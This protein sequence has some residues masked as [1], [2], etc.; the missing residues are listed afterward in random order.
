MAWPRGCRRWFAAELH[1]VV[2]V[3]VQGWRN[4]RHAPRLVA[5]AIVALPEPPSM[6][7]CHRLPFF[8]VA[9]VACLA[10]PAV[11]QSTADFRVLPYQLNPSLD[12]IQLTWFTI[13]NVPGT[14]TV[15]GP[16]LASPLVLASAPVLEPV[17]DYQIPAELTAGGAFPFATTAIFAAPGVPARNWRHKITVTGLQ[18]DSEY[19]FTVAQGASSYGNTFRTAPTPATNRPLRFIAISDSETLV[20]GRTRFR[21]W[22]RTTPQAPNSTGRPAGTGRGRDQYFLTETVGYQENI[23]NIEARNAD[24]LIFAGDL[25]EGTAN[26]CQ[27]RWDEFWRHNAGEYDDLFCGLPFVAAIGNNCIYNGGG[28]ITANPLV[29]Y[30]RQQ[31]SAY[32][33]YPAN[34][35]PLA[36]DLYFR[37]DYGPVT[38]IT[39]CSV[40][41]LGANDNVAPPQGQYLNVN[42]PDNRDTNRA[43]LQSYPYGDLPD[44]N[45]GTLQWNWAVQELAAAR[46][47]GQII[48]VQWHH[49]PFSRGIHGTSVT[50]TQ[51]G[52]AMRIYAPLMEQ[53]RVAGVFCGHSEVAEMS[54]FDLNTDGYGVHLWDV[55]AAGDGL[56]GVE[57]APGTTAAAITAWR[58]NPLNP[59][60]AAWTANPYHRWSA[61]QSE[62]ETWNGNQLLSGGK[63][64]GFLECDIERLPNGEYRLTFQNWHTFPLN[65]GDAGFTVTGYELRPYQTRVVLEGPADDLQPV[66]AAVRVP[67][68]AGCHG[69]GLASN[70]PRLDAAWQLTA[71]GVDAVSPVALCYFGG[72]RQDPGLPLP[73]LGLAA[74]GCFVH[75]AATFGVLDAPVAG[76]AA[77]FTV[78]VPNQ[79]SLLGAGVVVQSLALSTANVA[80]VATSNGIDAVLGR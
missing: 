57:D 41:S 64:Y 27:R 11:A 55:G 22:A 5:G 34:N 76:G 9:A 58:S 70:A 49:T 75:V 38:V 77:G 26:E 29:Q 15:T 61:D 60:G 69:L 79:V 36:K 50:S 24:L 18:A 32:F 14:L 62:P 13:A 19:S 78:T 8:A 3:S 73:S 44:F 35:D 17:L 7:S 45:I 46:A 31:W 1:H 54:Y 43:W 42:F 51:S 23:K 52:E 80:G 10:A 21:E 2:I 37:T 20:L 68:G 30:A 39:L 74:P 56:R 25:I 28:A 47:A 33:D 6:R 4:L 66:P 65:A 67:F 71:A 72:S 48:F 59:D 40:G 63:H 16:G 12:G 53:Y